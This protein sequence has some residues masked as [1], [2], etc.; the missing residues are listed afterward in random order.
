MKHVKNK[1]KLLLFATAVLSFAG[2]SGDDGIEGSGE[3]VKIKV[4]G[5]A[6]V[7]APLANKVVRLKAANGQLFTTTTDVN[8][9][10]AIE[11]KG[12]PGPYL[13][14][15]PDNQSKPL[16][17]VAFTSGTANIH[18][19]TD[20]VMRNWY[21][22]KGHDLE[23]EFNRSQSA[24]V[25][26]KVAEIVSTEAAFKSILKTG[27]VEY[28]VSESFDFFTSV[29]LAN[30]EGMDLYLDQVKVSTKYS[31]INVSLKLSTFGSEANIIYNVDLNTDF[32]A[33]DTEAPTDPNNLQILLGSSGLVV[34]WNEATDNRGVAGYSV[35]RDGTQIATTSFPLYSDTG[36][37]QPE[38]AN[39]YCY[40]VQAFDGAG[41]TSNKIPL[42]PACSGAPTVA[43]TTPPVKPATPVIVSQASQSVGISWQPTLDDT[44]AGVLGYDVYRGTDSNE[45]NL[46]ATTVASEYLDLQAF[47][48]GNNCYR[49]R[50]FDASR[51]T[52]VYS[53]PVCVLMQQVD[54]T[55]PVTTV[56][57]AAG[58]YN[59]LIEVRLA[60]DDGIGDSGCNATYYSF[61]SSTSP[62]WN[63]Y[64]QP[65]SISSNS[66][67]RYYS[68]DNAGNTE[69]EKNASYVISSSGGTLS[70][71]NF[72]ATSFSVNEDA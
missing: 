56:N 29:F 20:L 45:G 33:N 19:L 22:V 43:D 60:C 27:M 70:G 62:N 63:L 35:F 58:T 24:A 11:I 69:V 38:P 9:N 17:S 23:Y 48:G 41:L 8:G 30:S 47:E 10:Y 39:G 16:Y 61:E 31:K 14:E 55:A 68:V 71:I 42:T 52:S 37:P 25:L 67:L 53:D 34:V 21:S 5:T 12:Q 18:P 7:G 36:L 4:S 15:V 1:F 65:L 3:N 59:A 40:Q 44:G 54:N 28:G 13:I 50:A 51:N 6:A 72:V 57:P 49:V 46:I 32:T 64:T 66:T 2:C 26:P